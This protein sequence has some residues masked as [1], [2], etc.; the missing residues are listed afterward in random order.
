MVVFKLLYR[1]GEEA[2][3]GLPVHPHMLRHSCGFK[4]ANYG[5]DTRSTQYYPDHKNIQ[6]MVP[7]TQIS[8]SRFKDF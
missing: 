1:T 5:H 4:L 2:K 3:L 8:P 7:Y 6:N